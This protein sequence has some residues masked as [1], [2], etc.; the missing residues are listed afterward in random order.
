MMAQ[1]IGWDI[2][3]S[4]LSPAVMLSITSDPESDEVMKNTS[5]RTIASGT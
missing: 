4:I 2:G 5:T 1:K 3:A